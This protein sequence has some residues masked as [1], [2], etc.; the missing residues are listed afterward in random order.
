MFLY[1]HLG[2]Y[3]NLLL[4]KV[5]EVKVITNLLSFMFILLPSKKYTPGPA[6]YANS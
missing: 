6:R 2:I 5:N 3:L 1:S 4:L